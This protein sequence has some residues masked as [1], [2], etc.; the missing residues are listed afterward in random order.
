MMEKWRERL[1]R[2]P[3]RTL[4]LAAL[5]ALCAI[6]LGML[7]QTDNSGMTQEEARVARTLSCVAG[8]GNVRVTLYYSQ[9]ESAFSGSREM[10]GAVAV[11]TGAGDIAVRLNLTQALETLLNLPAGSVLVLDMEDEK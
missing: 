4:A 3:H 6:L 7:A 11:A 9:A 5:L 2:I 10:L 8:A 1:N